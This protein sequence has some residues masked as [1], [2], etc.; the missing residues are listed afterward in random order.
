MWFQSIMY[1][2][3]PLLQRHLFLSLGPTCVSSSIPSVLSSLPLFD[4]SLPFFQKTRFHFIHLISLANILSTLFHLFAVLFFFVSPEHT[5]NLYTCHPVCSETFEIFS[6]RGIAT[7]SLEDVLYGL[8]LTTHCF[9]RDM[10][11]TSLLSLETFGFCF[12]VS[13]VVVLP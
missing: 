9:E 2:Q 4:S 1:G 12:C 6:C 7:V 5:R 11:K 10:P 13:V 8:P 3:T